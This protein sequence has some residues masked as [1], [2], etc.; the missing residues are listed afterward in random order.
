MKKP[1]TDEQREKQ[2][3]ERLW[4]DYFNRYL[5]EHGAITEKQ[6]EKMVVLIAKRCGVVF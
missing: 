5:F 4:L 6:Y 3:T 2:M 1:L